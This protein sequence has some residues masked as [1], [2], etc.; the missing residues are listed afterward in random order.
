MAGGRFALGLGSGTRGVRRWYGAEL[1]P[2][3]PRMADYAER[4]RDA[5][6]GLDDPPPIFGAALNPIMARWIRRSCDGVVLHPVAIARH[7]LDTRLRPELD[8]DGDF[9]VAAWCVTSIDADEAL[10][11]ERARRQLAFYFSTPSYRTVAV[12]T[13]WEGVPIAVRESFDASER[14]ASWT[15]LAPLVPDAVVDEL[16]LAGTPDGVRARLPELEA[17]LAARGIGELVL[18]TVGA[19]GTEEEIVANCELIAEELGR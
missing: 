17:D 4:L 12:G 2:A 19:D 5:W 8:G 15:E 10:A 3:G 13:D 9:H 14:R 18:Q 11:R 6:E 16:C 1:D 7:H